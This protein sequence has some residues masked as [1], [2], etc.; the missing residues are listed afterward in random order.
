MNTYTVRESGGDYH[1]VEQLDEE[2]IDIRGASSKERI[3][4]SFHHPEQDEMA[5]KEA[6]DYAAWRT[7]LTKMKRKLQGPKLKLPKRAHIQN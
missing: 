3:I 5:R 4:A 2:L 6:E 7:Q 1:V